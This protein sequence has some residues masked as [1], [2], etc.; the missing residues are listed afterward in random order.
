[1]YGMPV[2]P[3][4]QRWAFTEV[5]HRGNLNLA[6]T[7]STF[8]DVFLTGRNGEFL[9]SDPKSDFWDI[10]IRFASNSMENQPQS[11]EIGPRAWNSKK[12]ILN[13]M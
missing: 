8:Q 9:I 6:R 2:W 4:F 11:D 1:M 12:K 3:S 13:R 5:P 10:F 7:A